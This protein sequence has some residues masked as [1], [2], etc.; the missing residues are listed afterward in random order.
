MPALCPGAPV[1][2]G[3]VLAVASRAPQKS[4]S[5]GLRDCTGSG[6]RRR[7]P[8]RSRRSNR[9]WSSPSAQAWIERVAQRV[10]EQ[11]EAE[12]READRETGRDREPG[13]LVEERHALPAQHQPPGRLRLYDAEA[14]E[15]Q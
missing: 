8:R 12:D 11:V 2:T 1:G 6:R 10:A 7:S 9:G 14:K 4:T 3:T 13:S 5:P 15:R